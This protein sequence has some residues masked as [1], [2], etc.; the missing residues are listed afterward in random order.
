MIR[1]VDLFAGAGGMSLGAELAGLEVLAAV[2]H[3]PIAVASH[4]AN[5]PRA[6]HHCEDLAV[7]D[8]YKLPDHDVMLAA[9]VCGGH[10]KARGKERAHHDASRSTA[11]CV[12][13]VAEAKRPRWLVIE[14]VPEMLSWALFPAWKHALELL[15]YGVTTQVVRAEE[16]GE[17]PQ[18]RHR[19]VIVGHL[20]RPMSVRIEPRPPMAARTV[21]DLEGGSWRPWREYAPRSVARIEAAQRRRGR[22]VLVPYYGSS[23]SHA[24]VSL[25]G[26]IGTLTTRDRYVLVRG[27]L[28]RVLTVQ[29]QLALSGFPRDYALRGTRREQVMQVGNAVPPP[30]AAA[31]LR[32]LLH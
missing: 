7:M 19:L 9:P 1:A 28:A 24:G 12:V 6:T 3:W 17:V 20:G 23:S 10:A 25:D 15:G 26:P 27:E 22:D 5:H 13:R 4:A 29:E 2:D 32:S 31:V 18:R 21:L 16:T 8:P 30:L 11:W 14:N